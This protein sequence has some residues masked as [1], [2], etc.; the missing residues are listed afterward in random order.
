M[1]TERLLSA[2]RWRLQYLARRARPRSPV[3]RRD[4]ELTSTVGYKLSARITLPAGGAHAGGDLRGLVISPAIGQ[5]WRDLESWR[6]PV[7]PEEIARLGYAVLSFDPAGRGQSWGEEDFGGPEHQDE[8]QVAVRHLAAHPRVSGRVGLLSLSMGLVA[9]AGALADDPDLPVAW[10][11]DWE[12]PCDREIL[13]SGGTMMAPAAGH[14]MDDEGWWGPREAARRIGL[15]RCPYVRLQALPDHAQPQETRHAARMI[16]AA[17]DRAGAGAQGDGSPWF[18][19]NDHPRNEIPDRPV[20]LPGGPLQA[21]R[22]IL[23]KLR[24]LR[25]SG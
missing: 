24:A 17:A 20:W 23:R 10:L 13:T 1:D 21:N 6:S 14:A 8:I 3:E 5:G 7:S 15:A 16:R 2:A 11:L 25:A 12:G 18:Q 9:A 22:A 4:I 19:L